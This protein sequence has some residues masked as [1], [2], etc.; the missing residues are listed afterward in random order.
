MPA[1]LAHAAL[2]VR[3]VVEGS[4]RKAGA[5]VR[6]SAQVID[7]GT[8]HHIWAQRYDRELADVFEVQDEISDAISVSMHPKLWQ[9]EMERASAL[10]PESL[11]AWE[12]AQ[13]GFWHWMKMTRDHNAQARSFFER[14]LE[15]DPGLAWAIEGVAGTHYDWPVAR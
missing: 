14:A 7:A 15:L 9:A 11:D 8:G 12:C 5:R 3:Y 10:E 1:G 13:R 2:D 4:V 6:I